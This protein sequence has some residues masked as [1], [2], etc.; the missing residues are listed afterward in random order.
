MNAS[1]T[2]ERLL[3]EQSRLEH[4][5]QQI[6]EGFSQSITEETEENTWDQ[7]IGDV[8]AITFEREVDLTVEDNV[9]SVLRQIDRALEKLDEG[10]YGTC[11]S[12][13]RPINESRLEIAPWSSLCIDC[14]RLEERG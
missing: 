3:Q 4:D 8:S 2:R 13:G 10:S 5:L 1:D 6:E 9:R 7:H 11:D 14:K 12:C